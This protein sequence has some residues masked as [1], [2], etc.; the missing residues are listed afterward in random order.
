MAVKQDQNKNLQ[1]LFDF[2]QSRKVTRIVRPK[3]LKDEYE[4]MDMTE[5]EQLLL[6]LTLEDSND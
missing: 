1:A 3:D 2:Y 4:F 6:T 5:G